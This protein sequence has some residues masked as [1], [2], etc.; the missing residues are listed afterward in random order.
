ISTSSSTSTTTS[1]TLKTTTTRTSTTTTSTT[2]STNTSSSSSSSSSTSTTATT[3]STS[4]TSPCDVAGC[5]SGD[6]CCPSGCDLASDADCLDAYMCDKA[7]A[8][9]A[10]GGVKLSRTT[11]PVRGLAD[12]FGTDTCRFKKEDSV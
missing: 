12:A 7:A 6:G 1:T 3:S 8:N 9:V 4:T 5:T 10:A 11:P 2:T